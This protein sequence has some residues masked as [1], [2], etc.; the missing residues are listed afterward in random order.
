V[1][2]KQT[3]STILGNVFSENDF[4]QMNNETESTFI[5]PGR[6]APQNRAESQK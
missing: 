6:S 4:L 2:E 3:L 1:Q 5:G